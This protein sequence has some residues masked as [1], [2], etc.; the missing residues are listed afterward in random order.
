[1]SAR[2]IESSSTNK[3]AL[4][5]DQTVST[6]LFTQPSNEIKASGP[7]TGVRRLSEV[8]RLQYSKYQSHGGRFWSWVPQSQDSNRT[9]SLFGDRGKLK[10]SQLF[11][12]KEVSSLS[13]VPVTVLTVCNIQSCGA[14]LYLACQEWKVHMVSSPEPAERVCGTI[15]C[16]FFSRSPRPLVDA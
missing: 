7:A 15:T 3:P 4:L 5:A 10:R 11:C 6:N 14:T 1:M 16:V 13:V 2:C 12:E 8:F 9:A